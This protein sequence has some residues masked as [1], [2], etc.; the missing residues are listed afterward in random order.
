MNPVIIWG[1]WKDQNCWQQFCDSHL[2]KYPGPVVLW[3]FL[4]QYVG[5]TMVINKIKEPQN[6]RVGHR[7]HRRIVNRK[8]PVWVIATTAE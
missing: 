6:T 2:S 7:H 4:S 1:A 5:G 3:F 8:I